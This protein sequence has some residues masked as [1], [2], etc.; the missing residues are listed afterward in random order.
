MIVL[1][2]LGASVLNFTQTGGRTDFFVILFGVVMRFRDGSD[3]GAASNVAKNSEKVRR[4]PWQW[5]DKRSGKKAWA[6]TESPNSPRPKNG[7]TGEEQSQEHAHHF[8]WH[9]LDCS[10][11][12]R[13]NSAYCCDF[14]GD[15]VKM[16]EDFAPKLKI[17]LKGPQLI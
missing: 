7:E 2:I 5:L 1:H 16:C 14:Y 8:L 4:R 3:K 11:G 9:Q 6:Y 15:C 12:Q 17:N 10:Q 13:V